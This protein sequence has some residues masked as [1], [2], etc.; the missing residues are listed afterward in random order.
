M[1][2]TLNAKPPKGIA[3]QAELFRVSSSDGASGSPATTKD[4]HEKY[5]GSQGDAFCLAVE[6]LHWVMLKYHN[7]HMATQTHTCNIHLV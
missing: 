2:E 3:I 6:K 5:P 1:A 7:T 4:N